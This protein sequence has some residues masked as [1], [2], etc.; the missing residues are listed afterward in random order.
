MNIFWI[1]DFRFW[2]VG[3]ISFREGIDFGS[4]YP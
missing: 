3:N 4:S 1:L 2:I